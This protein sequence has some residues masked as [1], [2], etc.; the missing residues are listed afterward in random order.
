MI[1]AVDT[2]ILL[3][4]LI[5]GQPFRESS[6]GLLEHHLAK[7]NLIICEIVFAELASCFPSQKELKLFL[8]DTG[9]GLVP[10]NEKSLYV[11]GERWAEYARKGR[12]SRFAC[13]KCGH[14]FEVT[15]PKCATSATKRLHVLGDFLVG[16]HALVQA[17][18]ILSRDLG[19]YTTYF[20][21]LDLVGAE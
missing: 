21:D 18:C 8:S 15:C 11:A 4:I 5:P 6:K 7:G 12:K 13:G 10:S 20:S 9:M 1:T 19:V 3:D 17:D 16:A 2:N 14:A